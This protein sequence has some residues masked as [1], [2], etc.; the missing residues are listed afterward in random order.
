LGYFSERLKLE[1]FQVPSRKSR[2]RRLH[3]AM[4]ELL[5]LR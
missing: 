1:T 4:W 5:L 3:N 2:R